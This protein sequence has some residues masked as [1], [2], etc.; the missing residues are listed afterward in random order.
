MGYTYNNKNYT[1]PDN[2]DVEIIDGTGEV[3]FKGK[4]STPITLEDNSATINI[5]SIESWTITELR[6][7]CR[8]NKVKGYT[9][10]DKEQLI[11]EVK[12]VINKFK[13][14]EV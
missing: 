7:T 6:Y 2:C 1:V 11:E 12:K 5:P 14:D 4:G 3:L 10:M 13:K 8:R 9:K